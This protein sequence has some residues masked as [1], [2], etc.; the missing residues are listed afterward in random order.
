MRVGLVQT[1]IVWEDRAANLARL[2]PKIAQAV[3]A[4][5]QLVVL[6]EMFASGFSLNT[7]R[8][9]EPF[10]GPSSQFL[11]ES[12]QR[13]GTYICGSIAERSAAGTE[14]RPF[15]TLV[16]AEPSGELR[17]YQKIHPFR[18]GGEDRVF[19][20]GSSWLT[21]PIHGVRCSFFICYDLRFADEFWHCAA[22][23]DLF[24]VVANWPSARRTHWMTLLG[25]RAIE[26]QCYVVG[27]NRV[28]SGGGLD[29]AGDSRLID[30]R[31][32]L[33]VELPAH[34]ERLAIGTVDPD[35][36]KAWRSAFPT[37]Q[38]RREL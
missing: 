24:V 20:P 15:N 36:V 16:L 1:D 19:A 34:E 25:A 17:R 9:A 32:E 12:A 3:D 10:D 14:P 8:T 27:V 31:G 23:T 28:G 29:Y 33:Q 11:R 7:D 35:E 2:A 26:N 6:P 37:F 30:P 5:A 4:G 13:H 22:A 21:V 38:D 18:F